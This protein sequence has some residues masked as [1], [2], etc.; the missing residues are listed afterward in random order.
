MQIR[1]SNW[2]VLVVFVKKIVALLASVHA[3]SNEDLSKDEH[4]TIQ[5]ELDGVVGDPTS[6]TIGQHGRGISN[7]RA[8]FD[9]T[10]ANGRLF[11]SK[12]WLTFRTQ[13]T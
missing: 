4:P 9:A 11:L 7:Q 2:L 6:R 5:I 12:N 10:N 1:A 3:G 13:W 8:P